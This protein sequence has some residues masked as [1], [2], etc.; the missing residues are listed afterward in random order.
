MRCCMWMGGWVGGWEDDVPCDKGEDVAD[1]GGEGKEEV[2][3]LAWI[4]GPMEWVG[5]WVD[6]LRKM[7]T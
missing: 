5:G 3:V 6:D 7:K 2:V 1:F 4:I